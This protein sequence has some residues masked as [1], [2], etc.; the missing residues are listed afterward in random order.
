MDLYGTKVATLVANAFMISAWTVLTFTAAGAIGMCSLVQCSLR[1]CTA[2]VIAGEEGWMLGFSLFAASIGLL[3]GL[4]HFANLFPGNE[5]FIIGSISGFSDSSSVVFLIFAA[6][7]RQGINLR[8]IFIGYICL[9][10]VGNLAFAVLLM[11]WQ[12]VPDG[13]DVDAVAAQAEHQAHLNSDTPCSEIAKNTSIDANGASVQGSTPIFSTSAGPAGQVAPPA[14]AV[15]GTSTTIPTKPAVSKFPYLL[16][17]IRHQ[18]CTPLFWGWVLHSASTLLRF[19]F[20]VAAVNEHLDHLG[21]SGTE[22]SDAFGIILSCGLVVVLAVGQV[23]DRWGLHMAVLLP[24]IVGVLLSVVTLLPSLPLQAVGFLLAV[25]Y[26]GFIFTT[27][28]AIIISEFGVG[29]YGRLSGL[30]AVT[31]GA[32]NFLQQPLLQ[33][34]IRTFNGDFF[35]ANALMGVLSLSH[36]AFAAYYWQHR[37]RSGFDGSHPV[38]WE[39][40]LCKLLPVQQPEPMPEVDVPCESI[41]AS[42]VSPVQPA[43]QASDV[44]LGE[45]GAGGVAGEGGEGAQHTPQDADEAATEDNYSEEVQDVMHSEQPDSAVAAAAVLPAHL[46]P[47]TPAS[48]TPLQ[49]GLHTDREDSEGTSNTRQDSEQ[50]LGDLEGSLGVPSP[51]EPS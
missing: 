34:S 23:M 4:F 19:N 6:L 39:M 28:A 13:Y 37:A 17:P 44:E 29:A 35:V 51:R 48:P 30:V 47:P 50:P 9:A 18:A 1:A 49:Q 21:Q 8:D 12:P 5:S 36:F 10:L 20:Y 25:V 22:Y 46:P 41:A 3:D 31:A 2:A 27:Y 7:F 24:T 40:H 26:R 45:T 32:L 15:I 43:V 16:W 14:G 42:A 38:Q 11:P 33:M